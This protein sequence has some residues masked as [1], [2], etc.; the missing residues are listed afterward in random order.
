MKKV[1]PIKIGDGA[2]FA[3]CVGALAIAYFYMEKY[4][5]L[6]PCPLCILDRITLALMAALFAAGALFVKP[7]GFGRLALITANMTL[8]AFGFVFSGRH[9]WL[10][11]QPL[12]NV[13]E[14]LADSPAARDFAELIR[15]AFDAEADC[16]IIFYEFFG[17]TIPDMTLLLF[18]GLGALLLWQLIRAW[19]LSD[20][21]PPT[22]D[23]PSAADDA[24]AATDDAPT[25]DNAPTPAA[26]NAPTTAA[27]N[28]PKASS[29]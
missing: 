9:V 24:P 10:Q 22:A 21:L 8:L 4:L 18:V 3:L 23:Y 1:Y 29:G 14:C 19:R 7:R 16:G 15:R 26:D 11:N 12:A 20:N 27:D 17:L 13:G 25:A 2:G 6:T 5:G 28:A